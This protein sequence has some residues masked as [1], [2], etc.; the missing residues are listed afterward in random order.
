MK[1]KQK[2]RL[3]FLTASSFALYCKALMASFY[4]KFAVLARI[5]RM[6][7]HHQEVKAVMLDEMLEESN[8]PFVELEIKQ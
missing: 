4:I 8:Q 5:E 3:A 6:K 7:A 2:I 1:K